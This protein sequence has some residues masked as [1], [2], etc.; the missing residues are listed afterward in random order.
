M[1]AKGV[2]VL[3]IQ[4]PAIH[5]LSMSSYFSDLGLFLSGVGEFRLEFKV[6]MTLCKS[7]RDQDTLVF[8]GYLD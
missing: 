7:V 2:A 5:I 6:L 8:H 4:N 3:Q 1:V